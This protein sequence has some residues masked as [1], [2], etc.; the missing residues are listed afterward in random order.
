MPDPKLL[1]VL[2]ASPA[3]DEMLGVLL[4]LA[5]RLGKCSESGDDSCDHEDE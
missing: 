4:L 2:R 3:W 1:V 5:G